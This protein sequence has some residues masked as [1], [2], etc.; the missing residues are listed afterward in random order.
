MNLPWNSIPLSSRR[1]FCRAMLGSASAVVGGLLVVDRGPLA[2][3]IEHADDYVMV[4]GWV[5][6]SNDVLLGMSNS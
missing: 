2:A 6:T 5:L 4:N 1:D 3:N